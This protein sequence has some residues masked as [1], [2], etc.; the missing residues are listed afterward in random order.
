ME[1]LLVADDLDSD[2]LTGTMITTAQNLAEGAFP[3]C[4]RDLIPE[5]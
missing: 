5:R 1:A 4:V 2:G 3:K